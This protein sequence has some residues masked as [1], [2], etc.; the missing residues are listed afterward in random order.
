MN[1]R[2]GSYLARTDAKGK[3][4]LLKEEERQNNAVAW[5]PAP[6]KKAFIKG[7]VQ[8]VLMK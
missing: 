3:M 4:M 2:I 6:Y 5:I 8:N 1:D 7:F